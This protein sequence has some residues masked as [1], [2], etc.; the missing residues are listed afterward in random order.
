MA[1]TIQ[2]KK[3]LFASLPTLASGEFG[4]CTDTY[5]L[6][7]GTG[8]ANYEV[9]MEALFD[10]NTIIA[11]NTDNTPAALTV[12]EQ[13]ILGRKTGGSIAALSAAEIL[14][15]IGVTSGADVT[16]SNAPQAHKDSHDP[17]DGGD[18]LDTAVAA[19][20]SAVVAAGVGTSH[21]YS[22]AD[23][24]HA[25][26]HAI[27]DNHL[28]TVDGSPTDNDFAKFTASGLEGRSYS[29]TMGDLSGTAAA[30][31]SMNSQK[32]TSLLDPTDAQDAASKAYVDSVA[33][34]LN[35][36]DAVACATTANISL[37]A[38]QT[39]DGI[40]TSTDR[41][42]V[43]SQTDPIENGIYVTAAGAW[44]RA[45]DMDAADE[46]AGSFV[47]ISDG[48]TLGNTGWVCT[49]E[50]ESVVIDT[51]AITFS[52][53]SDAGYVTASTGLL[54]SG[55]DIQATGVLEDL[56]TL[57]AAASDSQFIVATGAGAFAYE[58]GDTVR[59]SLGLAIGTNVLAQQTIGIANDNLLEVDGTPV[60]GEAAVFTT[61]GINSL[62][63]SEF[64]TAFNMEAG[65]DY[66]A[67]DADLAA[68]AGLTSAA[69]KIPYFTASETASLLDLATTVGGTGS[70][71]T[72]VSEQ[73]IRE[74]IAAIA[75]SFVGLTDTPANYTDAGLKVVRVNTGADA[76]EFVSFASTYLEG[77]PTEN[78][79]TK[80]PTSEWAF[81][82]SAAATGVHGA[83][84]NTLLHSGS[85][86]DGGAFA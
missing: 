80:A 37:T 85:T 28:V 59:T 51:D 54:K 63:E 84:G 49:N 61:A 75:T 22:R 19:E 55:N 16:G 83:G 43:R 25:I 15:I 27:T 41:V 30:A 7:M 1:N 18:A 50:P 86:I 42:L 4:W 35:V 17:N 81:D 3:G 44:A 36:H 62:S 9:L 26:S 57:G 6:F 47:F 5:Q 40:L 76:L 32:I 72:L 68:L 2:V 73:G 66:Q 46:V 60:N 8:A 10:A 45:A 56:N 23:H 67:Y 33:Q 20:I 34:G 64:K 21:S 79:A 13:T 74:A 24:I 12:A 82:H 29:E 39:L 48:T 65:T 70:D 11:A 58:S 71:T 52:Q 14:A 77:S 78:L 53:F 69:N 38:E 31:F